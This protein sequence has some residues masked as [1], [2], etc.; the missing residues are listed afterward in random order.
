MLGALDLSQDSN[1]E[2]H[3]V[4]LVALIH[5]TEAHPRG[6]PYYNLRYTPELRGLEDEIKRGIRD[7]AIEHG[8]DV[9]TESR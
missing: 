2:R 4:Q 5:E 6:E 9:R 7:H 1:F 3:R 8:V